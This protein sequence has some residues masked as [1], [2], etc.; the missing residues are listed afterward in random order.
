MKKRLVLYLVIAILLL[1]TCMADDTI[2]IKKVTMSGGN[3][4]YYNSYYSINQTNNFTN[5]ITVINDLL[6]INNITNN[7]TIIN[8][9]TNDYFTTNNITI[10][11]TNNI[12]NE[13]VNNFTTI[14]NITN[15]FTISGTEIVDMV[16]NWSFDKPSYATITSLDNY[17]LKNGLVNMVGNWTFDKPS[18]VPWA[19][20]VNAIGNWSL[21]KPNYATTTMISNLQS[22]ISSVNTSA[23]LK[24]STGGCNAGQFVNQTTTTG[25]LCQ[26]PTVGG[27]S[28]FT[29]LVN[30]TKTQ[31]LTSSAV[32]VAIPQLT[33]SIPS[34]KVANVACR[35]LSM[36][37]TSTVGVQYQ[38]NWTNILPSYHNGVMLSGTTASLTAFASVSA[39]NATSFNLSETQGGANNHVHVVSYVSGVTTTDTAVMT[40]WVKPETTGVVSNLAGST[41]EISYMN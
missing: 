28:V 17:V 36:S 6:T 34:D 20:L 3:I 9:I 2:I 4:S 33:A 27:G 41:C 29:E 10:N 32:Y 1:N 11:V 23:Q 19:S 13:V 12:T 16:G 37:N 8:N 7:L 26:I 40:V 38:I 30:V 24:A 22:N 21:D 14:N 15:N 25:V 18:Y 39:F 31:I 5:N 35:F